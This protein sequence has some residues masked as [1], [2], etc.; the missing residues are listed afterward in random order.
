MRRSQLP[1]RLERVHGRDCHL[2][3]WPTLAPRTWTSASPPP[4]Q[5]KLQS[6]QEPAIHFRRAAA[7]FNEELQQTAR[8]LGCRAAAERR[9]SADFLCMRHWRRLTLECSSW[10]P[11]S[12]R[13]W[14][15]LTSRTMST[16]P[17]RWLSYSGQSRARSSGVQVLAVQGAGQAGWPEGHLLLGRRGGDLLHAVLVRQERAG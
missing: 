2:A 3:A 11:R 8:R 15:L 16:A 4:T 14:S 12:S 13:S 10:K 1:G 5:G 17:S 9:C 7:E 6:T